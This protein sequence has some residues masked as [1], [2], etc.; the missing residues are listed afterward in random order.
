MRAPE[1]L[2]VGHPFNPVYLLPLV[3]L[4]GGRQTSTAAIDAAAA[5]TPTS[6]CIRCRCGAK[7]PAISPI[8]CRRRCGAR[9]CTWSTTDVATTGELDD[10][11]V[12]GP[13][14]RWAAM[15]TNLIYHLAGG[16]TGMRHMLRQFGPCLKWPWTKLEAP[17]LTEGLIDR[18]VE[19]TAGAGRRPLDP[20]ARAAARRLPGGDPAGAAAIRH[21]RRRDAARARGAA[22]RGMPHAGAHA[23]RSPPRRPRVSRA[24]QPLRLLETQCA[25]SGS[26]TTAT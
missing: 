22:V 21:R 16:E 14:L 9:S 10:S 26:T 23:T 12:Y 4:V 8:G 11:I 7:C 5:S 6:A 1:R 20:R 24:A 19:G 18:M 13:G 17:E 3:E 15:G 2:L 25:R